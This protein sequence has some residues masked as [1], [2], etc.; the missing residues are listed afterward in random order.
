MYTVCV[1]V[2]NANGGQKRV[3]DLLELELGDWAARWVLISILSPLWEW[4][5]FL[6]AGLAFQPLSCVLALVNSKAW[7]WVPLRTDE[8]VSWELGKKWIWNVGPMGPER[9]SC[10]LM[11]LVFAAPLCSAQLLRDMD[12]V[13]LHSHLQHTFVPQTQ[14]CCYPCGHLY[15][16]WCLL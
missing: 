16:S 1:P 9:F 3:S 5:V 7:L 15:S 14:V 2:P 8:V 13:G 11:F 6:T 4:T 10:Y 12:S